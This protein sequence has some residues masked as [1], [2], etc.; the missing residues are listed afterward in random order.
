[1]LEV[2]ATLLAHL[3]VKVTLEVQQQEQVMHKVAVVAAVRLLL[4][5]ME[6][7][8]VLEVMAALEQHLH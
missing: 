5:G 7:V 4:V 2:R 3:Q 8:Q 1:L 6:L